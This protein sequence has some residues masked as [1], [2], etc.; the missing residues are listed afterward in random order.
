M[1][2][3]ELKKEA[4]RFAPVISVERVL[5]HR[6]RKKIADGV[7]FT[8]AFLALPAALHFLWS[9]A[10]SYPALSV[11]TGLFFL[12]LACWLVLFMAEALFYSYYFRALDVISSGAAPAALTFEAAY[13]LSRLDED[14]ITQS[15]FGTDIGLMVLLRLGISADSFREFLKERK[16]RLAANVFAVES[17]DGEGGV[18]IA[19]IALSVFAADGEF[20]AFLRRFGVQ[21]K[22]LRG[23][24]LWVERSGRERRLFERWW[25]RESL[26]RVEGIGK[27][28]AYG[29]AYILDRYSKGVFAKGSAVALSSKFLSEEVEELETILARRREA[30]ALLVAQTLDEAFD[31]ILGLASLISRGRVLPALEHKR[32]VVLDQNKLVA[33][34]AG[35]A[36]FEGELIKIF[37][38]SIAAGNIILVFDD[39]PAF[40]GS[41]AAFG[42][43]V[44]S[45]MD[46]YLSSPA[47]Q[48]VALSDTER[49]HRFIEPNAALMSR[50]EKVTRRSGGEEAV[51][52]I[53]ENEADRLEAVEKVFFTYPALETIA[54]TADQYFPSGV[55]PDK[56]VDLLNEIVPKARQ[57]GQVIID[58]SEVLAL[59][60]QK[61]GIPAGEVKAAEAEKLINLEAILHKRI[62]GQE[63]AIKAI[64]NAL[65]RA[66]SGLVNPGRPLGSF[67]FL[68]PTGVGKTETTK[69]LA[70]AFFGSEG[71][72]VRL[73][74]SE[75]KAADAMDKLIGSFSSG[76]SGVLSSAL[77]D[78][79]YGVL[80]L[81]E[82]EKASRE[83]LDLF[84][85]VLDE[86]F[87]S[88]AGG[89]RVS[90]R[91][92]IIIA[93]SNAGADLIWEFLKE[94]GDLLS[95]KDEIVDA[96]VKSGIFKPEL[97]N[98]FDGVILFHPI[99]GEH[100]RDVAKLML[101]R[102]VKRLQEKGI[103]LVINDAL[104]DYLM[105]FGSDPKF[106]ARPMN[107]AIQDKVEQVIAD[108]MIKGEIKA[109]MKVEL[110][111]ADLSG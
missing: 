106:G 91:N 71:K 15:F 110:S 67:L 84:L 4:G 88:D 49:F 1:I 65:R 58:R 43:D 70:E 56:A 104:V 59:V 6:R 103:E 16:S 66:R 24:G 40:L 74:M 69:A 34:T 14:D 94:G 105:K 62:V 19:D 60:E 36:R 57:A 108:K 22:T 11:L 2:Y 95:R 30:N 96:L 26:G 18:G 87:F 38:E 31:L 100:L 25:S 48:V 9:G 5:P 42:S 44:V 64:S 63:E 92:L 21:G 98:R 97:L 99:A 47:L 33:I 83:V 86:G 12:V 27:D 28:W 102:L 23:V 7:G 45:I 73:D 55:M 29:G 101:E 79:P 76:R 90:A 46:P 54:R 111:A 78:H 81:D 17:R 37:E 13:A 82:F 77:R 68:G 107:R 35:K 85:Q 75:Y 41:A 51:L 3:E 32:V 50:F 93:T 53:L 109:G 72:I 10:A 8:A 61:T 89:K 52:K 39:L 20:A 80:L